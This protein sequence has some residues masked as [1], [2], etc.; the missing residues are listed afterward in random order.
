[1]MAQDF[2]GLQAEKQGAF[3]ASAQS[4]Q[5]GFAV[6]PFRFFLHSFLHNWTKIEEA[7]L[8][9]QVT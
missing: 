3:S 2:L 5:A 9:H 4:Q 6:L 8:R 1:M 7:F